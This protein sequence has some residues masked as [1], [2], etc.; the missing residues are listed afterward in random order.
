MD[1]APLLDRLLAYADEAGTHL[2]ALQAFLCSEHVRLMLEWNRRLN[3]TRITLP[4]QVILRHILDSLVPARW[5]PREGFALDVGSGAGFPGIPLKILHPALKM[6]LL[7]AQ[8][9]KIS[10]LRVVLA[11]LALENTWA[12]QGRWEEL[13][14]TLEGGLSAKFDL[15]T[16]RALRPKP[17]HLAGLGGL[18]T[19][20]GV[21]AWWTGPGEGAEVF[22]GERPGGE[23]VEL[24]AVHAYR[25]PSLTGQRR[26][27]IW[28]HRE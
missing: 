1:E 14:R 7:D 5:L 15:I 28:K 10:F 6:T 22:R 8:R 17:G 26:I 20:R 16:V 2:T 9:K 24:A 19:A 23:T 12:R 3:L 4:N 21:L 18:L 25:I 27:L 13:G 11:E